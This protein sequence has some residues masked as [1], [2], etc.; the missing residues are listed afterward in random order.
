MKA[1]L[2]IIT[3]TNYSKALLLKSL[4]EFEGIE[5]Y[6]ANV[7]LIQ[8]DIATGVKVM[9]KD[10]D[11]KKALQV[12]KYADK[13][14]LKTAAGKSENIN[15]IICPVDFSKDS[16]NAAYYALQVAAKINAEV[17]FMY[18]CYSMQPMANIFPDAFSY[19]IG[20]GNIFNDEKLEVKDAMN[21]FKGTINLYIKEQGLPELKISTNIVYED[22][23]TAI[24][25]YCKKHRY[26]MVIM[27]TK[28]L[29][30]SRN[31]QAGSIALNTIESVEIPVLVVPKEYSFTML[32]QFNT[33]Y[34]T[35]FD[36]R[37]FSSF[38]KL[39]S[40]I[41]PFDAK[42]HC[43]HIQQEKSKINK[44]MLDELTAHIKSV[45]S[46]YDVSCKL[47][48]SSEV[49]KSINEFVKANEINLISLSERKRNWLV[50]LFSK[51][52]V[53]DILFKVNTPL[54]VFKY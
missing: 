52:V 34:L 53:K 4:L 5:T 50:K 33:V 18:A 27:G 43:V 13:Q 21:K 3:S 47:I 51:S 31:Y 8:S 10:T 48:N 17:K 54:L 24:P 1:K 32:G 25:N 23:I 6:L 46:N 49:T 41:S 42:V 7:N 26:A 19:Q 29:G 14:E 16:L 9:V 38:R 30:K 15:K 40:I 36:D 39:M 28:G 35:D 11:A 22:P 12:I 45:Y 44:I 2:I 20:M 37:D